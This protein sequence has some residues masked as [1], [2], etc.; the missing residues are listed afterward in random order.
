LPENSGG[1]RHSSGLA[2]V[3]SAIKRAKRA[4]AKC[5]IASGLITCPDKP[6]TKLERVS[7]KKAALSFNGDRIDNSTACFRLIRYPDP[8]RIRIEC[9]AFF[10]EAA[11]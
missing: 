6:R 10:Q 11:G 1:G 9:Q 7:R 4:A 8:I 3:L 2:D 5:C